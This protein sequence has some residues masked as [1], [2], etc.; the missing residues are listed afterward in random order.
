MTREETGTHQAVAEPETPVT[1]DPPGKGGRQQVVVITGLSGAGKSQASKLFED[2]GF[3]CVDNLPP[4]L[5]DAFLGLRER[6]PERYRRVALVVDIRAGDPAPAIERAVAELTARGVPSE[7]VYLEANDASLIARFS[8]TRHLHPLPS[9][10]GVQASID[11]ERAALNRARRLATVVIDTSGLSI[12]QLRERLVP[13][14]GDDSPAAQFSVSLI[15]FG[16]KFGLPLEADLVF[17]VRFLTN[18][19]YVPDLRPLSGLRPEVSEYVLGQPSATRFLELVEQMVDLTRPA[20]L[21]EGKTRLTIALGCT[22][23]Y[24][25]SIALAEEL[26][27]RLRRADRGAVSVHHRELN[28]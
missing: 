23:G 13:L 26:A 5:I 16:F 2:F 10:S 18:P 1:R 3:Y 22:G 28:R 8:E 21:A 19:H 9:T 6:E 27:T 11:A 4:A 25:R 24:H 17:D 20:Y 15:T 12:G 14:I 7:V